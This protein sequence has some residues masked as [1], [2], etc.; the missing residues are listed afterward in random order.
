M[1]GRRKQ[2]EAKVREKSGNREAPRNEEPDTGTG[3]VP[4]SAAWRDQMGSCHFTRADQSGPVCES[5]DSSLHLFYSYS[6]ILCRVMVVVVVV[7]GGGGVKPSSQ[8]VRAGL[9]Q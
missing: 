5:A 2:P 9:Q 1:S 3:N 8:Q 6:L 7:E 4:V